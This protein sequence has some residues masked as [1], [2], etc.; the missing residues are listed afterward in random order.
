MDLILHI[1]KRLFIGMAAGVEQANGALFSGYRYSN[2]FL[3]YG[4]DQ[5]LNGIY[6]SRD[7][8]IN[9]GIRTDITIIR[10]M[11][12]SVRA[13][14]CGAFQGKQNKST[15][16]LNTWS[17][18]M[19]RQSASAGIH[20]DGNNHFYLPEDVHNAT[21]DDVVYVGL[22]ET[23]AKTYRGWRVTTSLVLDLLTHH[24]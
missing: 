24:N 14:Y 1:N 18:Q 10:Q 21:N 3:S 9:V 11:R 2:S 8:R 16:Y 13:E 20:E 12:L 6:R 15:D 7:N 23:F 4:T 19:Y 5:P 17:D 22:G